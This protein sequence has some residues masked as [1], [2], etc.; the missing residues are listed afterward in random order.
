MGRHWRGG[1]LSR[2]DLLGRSWGFVV[3]ECYG[4]IQTCSA[5]NSEFLLAHLTLPEGNND[6]SFVF[7]A[8]VS[9][10]HDR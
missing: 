5:E 9:L 10:N 7:G 3:G 1:G 8:I 2:W 4:D 6:I